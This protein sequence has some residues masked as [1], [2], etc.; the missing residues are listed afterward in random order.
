MKNLVLTLLFST[1]VLNSLQAQ[2]IQQITTLT[3]NDA[4]LEMHNLY[5]E[6]NGKLYFSAGK[7]LWVSDGTNS[8]TKI[9]K[10][11]SQYGK[12]GGFPITE[13]SIFCLTTLN[14][15][16]F[17][18]AFDSSFGW[19][20][21][22]SD[23]TTNGTKMLVDLYPGPISGVCNVY[24]NQRL[25][26]FDAPFA[27]ANGNIYFYGCDGPSG[28]E[29]WKSD[30]TVAGT[31]MI[32]DI[33]LFPNKG[34]ADT[35]NLR[36]MVV[37]SNGN[38]FFHATDSTYGDEFWVSDGTE[39]GT[40]M[41]KDITPGK[42]G[43]GQGY[44]KYVVYNDKVLF[45]YSGVLYITDG[46]EQN[47]QI[48]DS[49]LKILSG[50]YVVYN[51]KIYFY[52]NTLTSGRSLFESDGTPT[53]TKQVFEVYDDNITPG[54]KRINLVIHN[55]LLFFT[56]RSTGFSSQISGLWS[57]D[58]TTSGTRL[59]DTTFELPQN[60][61]TIN[62]KLYYRIYNK[63][64]STIDVWQSDGTSVGTKKVNHSFLDFRTHGSGLIRNII[65][66]G[67]FMTYGNN[68][69][70]PYIYNTSTLA[71]LY[72]IGQWPDNVPKTQNN[73]DI[74]IYPNPAIDQVTIKGDII[75]QI[76]ISDIS[77]SIIY[78]QETSSAYTTINTS[79]WPNGLYMVTIH[80]SD[81]STVYRK[82][83][84]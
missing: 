62:N 60:M 48:L 83:I 61:I 14:N 53:G 55:N 69:I 30:G 8:G 59:V 9:I 25:S 22:T 72:G 15:K 42:Y 19:E 64:D 11:F 67:N 57:S 18:T 51:S 70:F 65:I 47:T 43:I 39:T 52:G 24:H 45:N 84:K 38:I 31:K 54:N 10:E 56:G 26:N 66:A 63:V 20:L 6:L 37:T 29:L 71:Q 27:K 34:M 28:I 41:I 32:K 5:T 81:S 23:G 16:L 44:E 46:T 49:N 73:S 68:L 3:S 77:G 2:S 7:Y 17:F 78:K 35:P 21:W 33:N 75:T 50:D 79:S 74:S 40:K 1:L 4:K 58:G 13:A 80:L 82:I 12:I 76:S 36:N